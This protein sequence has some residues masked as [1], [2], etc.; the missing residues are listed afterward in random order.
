MLSE[1]MLDTKEVDRISAY[2]IAERNPTC[3][4]ADA[5]WANHL[6]PIFLTESF[7]KSKYISREKFM[8]ICGGKI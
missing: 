4:G 7:A 1:E 2:V 5:R 8:K 3:Y 6:Y